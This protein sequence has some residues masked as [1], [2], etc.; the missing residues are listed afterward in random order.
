MAN[1]REKLVGTGL[2]LLFVGAGAGIMLMVW[3]EPDQAEAPLWVVYA[4]AS[5][6]SFAGLWMILQTFGLTLLANLAGLA[7]AYLLA[8]PGLWMLFD[9]QGANCS[10]SG[11]MADITLSGPGTSWTCR[12]IFG[13]GSLLVL[14]FA[15]L[16][17][18]AAIRQARSPAR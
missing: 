8:V 15:L 17:T 1:L 5:T 14:L 7:V 2:G 10:V 18:R 3:R 11:A 13:I 12:G 6:F 16:L 9:G 4:A